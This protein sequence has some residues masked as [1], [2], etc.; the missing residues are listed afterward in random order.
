LT[1]DCDECAAAS[2]FG[3]QTLFP[4]FSTDQTVGAVIHEDG[5]KA[6]VSEPPFK[7]GGASIVTAAVTEEY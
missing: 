5:R 7:F 1:H 2:Q 6:F 3:V 4:G